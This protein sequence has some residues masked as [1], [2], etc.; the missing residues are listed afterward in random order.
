MTVNEHR[1]HVLVVKRYNN[2]R[3]QLFNS[4]SKSP[5]SLLFLS[6]E[7]MSVQPGN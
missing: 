2:M 7:K 5:H 6:F 3:S 1:F 4:L